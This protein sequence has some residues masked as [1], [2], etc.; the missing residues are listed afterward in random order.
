[1]IDPLDLTWIEFLQFLN[2][3]IENIGKQGRWLPIVALVYLLSESK[4]LAHFWLGS[5]RHPRQESDLRQCN[6]RLLVGYHRRTVS[7][8]LLG[9]LSGAFFIS[10][11]LTPLQPLDGQARK[12][13]PES[14]WQ[15]AAAMARREASDPSP[16][17]MCSE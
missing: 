1:M 13:R 4:K 2:K 17:M 8:I 16:R 9:L 14:G 3:Y 11:L 7:A 6:Q 15:F 5:P 12:C 10:L